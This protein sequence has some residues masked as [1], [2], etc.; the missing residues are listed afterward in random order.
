MWRS[1]TSRLVAVTPRGM[2]SLKSA[3]AGAAQLSASHA[4]AMAMQRMRIVMLP[5]SIGSGRRTRSGVRA[6]SSR[7]A[8]RLRR[9]GPS[10][11]WKKGKTFGQEGEQSLM[12]RPPRAHARRAS[13]PP[14][15]PLDGDGD[16]ARRAAAFA[17]GAA[18]PG[19]AEH[20]LH[21]DREPAL[22]PLC[23][24]P[25][26]ERPPATHAQEPPPA[27]GRD[28]HRTAGAQVADQVHDLGV[29]DLEPVDVHHGLGQPRGE[30]EVAEIVHVERGVNVDLRID[31]RPRAPDLLQ[32]VWAE[33]REQQ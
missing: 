6:N 17:H 3:R 1:Y 22:A 31:A 14:A 33:R 32:R 4:N 26:L 20:E 24:E 29:S 30:R 9:R 21:R 28:V 7:L 23:V 16:L 2:L 5:A 10:P 18:A 19:L 8:V 27:A 15:D 25:A 12:R 11:G 13:G